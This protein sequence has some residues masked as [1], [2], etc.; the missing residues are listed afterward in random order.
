M[1]ESVIIFFA[2]F[3]SLFT[4][5]FFILTFLDN[6]GAMNNPKIKKYPSVT[7]IIPAHKEEKGIAGTIESALAIDYPKDKLEIIVVENGESGDRTVEIANRYKNKGVKVYSLKKGGKGYAMNYVIARVKNDVVISMDA[8][9]FAEP[10]VLYKM[11]GYFDNP[12]VMAVAPTI[13]SKHQKTLAQRIQNVEYLLGGFARKVFQFIDSMY[14]TPGAF[15]AYRK[16]F[17]DKYGAYDEG[18]ITEDLE[19]ALRINSKGYKLANAMDASVYTIT[20]KKFKE[21]YWQRIRWFLGF[22]DAFIQYRSMLF[23]VR[24]GYLSGLVIPTAVISVFFTIYLAFLML[25]ES[26]LMIYWFFLDG[27]LIGIQNVNLGLFSNLVKLAPF[28][29]NFSTIEFA[30]FSIIFMGL[31]TF[32]L[33][34]KYSLDKSEYKFGYL[35]YIFLYIIIFASWWVGSIWYKLFGRELRFGGV[36][37]NNSVLNKYRYKLF[38]QS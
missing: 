35:I 17:F 15:T 21:L 10:D 38:P 3:V 1:I 20:P 14:V 26:A 28:S 27:S 6:L 33:A 9:S 2:L 31:L 34:K 19:I 18:H 13:K 16:K 5:T 37:W 25:K 8:D 24:H 23:G 4:G 7:I 32:Y 29:F 22:I 30:G 36:V 12:K 11:M